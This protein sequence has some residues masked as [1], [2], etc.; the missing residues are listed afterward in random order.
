MV[1]EGIIVIPRRSASFVPT[2]VV[3]VFFLLEL[4]SQTKAVLHLVFG[5]LVQGARSIDDLLVLLIIVMLGAQLIDIGN[6][7]VWSAASGSIVVVIVRLFC[8]KFLSQDET[9]LHL[10]LGILVERARAIKD[11]LVLLIVVTL[12]ARFI[13]DG[14]DVVWPAVVILTRLGSFW[15]ITTA[16][17]MVTT[18]IVAA[19]VVASI[20]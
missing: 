14:D 20:I 15:P 9:I 3:V 6:K 18:V 5:V 12:G 2:I 4:L 13:N 10:M 1:L 11:L 8:L 17:T 16:V 19:V 7:V